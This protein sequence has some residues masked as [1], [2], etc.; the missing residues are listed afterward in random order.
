MTSVHKLLMAIVEALGVKDDE[1]PVE[2]ARM[3]A[4]DAARYRA[5]RA[6]NDASEAE[7]DASGAGRGFVLAEDYV[8]T[9]AQ[10]DQM[11]DRLHARR[12]LVDAGHNPLCAAIPS[13]SDIVE[14]IKKPCNCGVGKQ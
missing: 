1:D 2:S 7:Q 8:L 3:V 14:G 5:L 10:L 11:T 4:H 9:A 13:P 12:V 6:W